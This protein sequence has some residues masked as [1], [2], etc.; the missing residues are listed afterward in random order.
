MQYT[1]AEIA[2]RNASLVYEHI[3][4]KKISNVCLHDKSFH[5]VSRDV[6]FMSNPFGSLKLTIECDSQK[7]D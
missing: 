6:K 7:T 5:K 1:H 4:D 3:K 2:C